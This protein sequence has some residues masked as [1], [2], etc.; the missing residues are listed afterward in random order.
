MGTNP[1]ASQG[2][3]VSAVTPSTEVVTTTFPDQALEILLGVLQALNVENMWRSWAALVEST[4]ALNCWTLEMSLALEDGEGEALL[5]SLILD[6]TEMPGREV[7]IRE[8]VQMEE[9]KEEEL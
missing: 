6:R 3:Q 4:S 8:V 2:P 9:E 7:E 5:L 1:T